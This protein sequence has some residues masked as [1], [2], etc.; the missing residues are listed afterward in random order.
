MLDEQNIVNV[1]QQIPCITVIILDP[2][3]LI[4]SCSLSK[5]KC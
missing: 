4:I 3:R 5:E 1:E 2:F